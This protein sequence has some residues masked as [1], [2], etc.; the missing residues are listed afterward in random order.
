MPPLRPRGPRQPCV[1]PLR[2][3]GY[4]QP[5]VPPPRRPPPVLAGLARWRPPRR[6]PSFFRT[7]DR[8]ASS[9][10]ASLGTGIGSKRRRRALAPLGTGG[11]RA[12]S[13]PPALGKRTESAWRPGA[14]ACS[15]A[16]RARPERRT[17]T[18]QLQ[19]P[20]L[21]TRP[22]R[23]PPPPELPPALVLQQA[24]RRIPPPH[25]SE[26]LPRAA[27]RPQQRRASSQ[28]TRCGPRILGKQTG[29]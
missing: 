9:G 14:A 1:H 20:S 24:L 26:R 10:P 6:R 16:A 8:Q 7:G 4:R 18:A 27:H 21:V 25:P 13:W 11:P 2:P 28:H 23:R 17:A 15:S 5:C 3:R 29:S 12:S 19:T 22:R